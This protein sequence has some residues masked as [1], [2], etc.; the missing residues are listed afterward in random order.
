MS[1]AG[2]LDDLVRFIN[3]PSEIPALVRSALVHYQ[4]ET[5]HPFADGNG[6]IGRLLVPL[7]LVRWGLM[8]QPA[9]YISD[10]FNV[11]R[12]AYI[13]GLWRV[14]RFG[15]WRDWIH[16]FV[17]A[18]RA[19]ARDAHDRGE[20]LLDLRDAYRARYQRGRTSAA[21]LRVIDM[22]FESPAI[23][24]PR[25]EQALRITF[26]TANAWIERLVQDGVLTEVTGRARNRIY[27]APAIFDLL[28]APPSFASA[29]SAPE[30]SASRT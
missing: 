23:T 5:I 24:V 21:L 30:D 9:L 15:A 6:R 18:A 27:L 29:S 20:R 10:F 25:V 2:L 13:D 17:L 12:E 22:L 14:S 1:I 8:S 28:D 7:L 4:F 3:A 26:P 16:F 11:H 19:Q